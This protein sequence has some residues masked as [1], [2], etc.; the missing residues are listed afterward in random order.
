MLERKQNSA[1]NSFEFGNANEKQISVKPLTLVLDLDETLVHSSK[2]R[3]QTD[4]EA[5]IVSIGIVIDS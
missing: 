2:V 1:G 5:L 4:H 3:P